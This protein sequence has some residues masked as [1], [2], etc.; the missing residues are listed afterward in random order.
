MKKIVITTFTMPNE[1]DDLEKTLMELNKASKYIKG[2]NYELYLALTVSDFLVDWEN[3]KLDKQYFID[4]FNKLKPLL[5]RKKR[6]QNINML[7]IRLSKNNKLQHSKPCAN[8]ITKLQT[9]PEQKGY[10]IKNIY[11]SND[12]EELVKSNLSHLEKDDLHHTNFYRNQK[13]N[14]R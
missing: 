4:R 2:E 12:D 7:V 13:M 14:N 5:N 6:L 1:I 11:Y 8:C 10:K 9:L 3:S